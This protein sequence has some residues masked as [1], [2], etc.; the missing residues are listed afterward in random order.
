MEKTDMTKKKVLF[1]ASTLSHLVNFHLPYLQD[2]RD[3]GYEVWTAAGSGGTRPIP[4]ADRQVDVPFHKKFF[5]PK[6]IAAIFQLRRLIIEEG[7]T[8]ISTHTTLASAVVRAAVLLTP[9]KRRPN[10]FCICHGYL[11]GEGDGLKKWAYLLPEKICAP[12]TDVLMVM[13]REDEEIAKKHRLSG[14]KLVFLHGMGLD[15]S[16]FP[17]IFPDEREKGRRELGFGSDEFLFVYA[18][19]FSRRKNQK[20]LIGAF[21]EA[22]QKNPRLRLLLAGT[23]AT[24]EECK[25]LAEQSGLGDRVRFLGYVEEMGWLYPLCDAAV[26]SSRIEGLPFNI[27]EAMAS[28]LPVIA[29]RVKGHTD[30]LGEDSPWLYPAGDESAL[31][32][33]LERA[34]ELKPVDWGQRL[35]PY[36]LENVRE[37]LCKE[38]LD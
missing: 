17:S 29:S 35:R 14:G 37:E 33:L 16:R 10:V 38:Y 24:L 8:C 26:S 5:S 1:C 31:A 19:E 15:S 12:V 21:G 34:E 32:A 18:A 36:L 20:E 25:A 3:W 22:A 30:L 4:F 9:K 11:F 7:F 13:N 6:N 23:G 2:F 27:M 28:G